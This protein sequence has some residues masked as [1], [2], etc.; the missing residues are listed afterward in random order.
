MR[1]HGV[2]L[3]GLREPDASIDCGNA[4]T[5]ARLL[6]GLLAGQGGRRFEL[7]GDDSLSSR[8]M[9]R[10]AA[11][12]SEMGAHVWRRVTGVC[13]CG[14]RDGPLSGIEHE[15]EVASAQV[16]SCVLLAGL[17]ADGRTTVVESVATRD[18]TERMLRAAGARLTTKGSRISVERAE[19]LELGEIDVP[20]DISAAA[21]FVVAA[22]LLPGSELI[23][24]G[25]GVNPSRTGLLDAL[26]R[27]GARIS[28]FNRRTQSGE[29]VA[30]LE[31]TH[32]ELVATEIVPAE[33]PRM[34]DELPLFALAAS[35]ARG[36]SRVRGAAELR[37]KESDRID[38][39]VDRPSRGRCA[40]AAD[41]G[42]LHGTRR[43]DAAARRRDR[44]CGRPPRRHRRRGRG[45]RLARGR[46]RAG[47]GGGGGIVPRLLRA[48]RVTR[49]PMIIAIDG[50][51]GAGKSTV[52][53]R[54]AERL[55]VRYLDTGAMYRAVTWLALRQAVPLEDGER[56][57]EL[58]SAH[59]VELD[60]AGHV[61]IAGED[62]TAAIRETRVDR[63]VPVVAAHPEVREVMRERQREL[64]AQADAVMEGR[65]IGTVVAPGADVKVYLTADEGVRTRRRQ[66]ERPDIGADALA[67]DLR[68]RDESDASRMEP[69][70]DAIHIDT[71][72]L[73]V[74]GVVS[75]IEELVRGV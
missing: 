59:P 6:P 65:D 22:T 49:Q 29:P 16:K 10:V 56:L 40:R 34:I 25:V 14:S 11:P 61:A 37:A 46:T 1:L 30:D 68:L 66:S 28:V 39:V 42:R 55:G 45:R 60:T 27:M 15:P 4:G 58:A 24:Q 51:A 53:R 32:A 21:P 57:G 20:G 74:D 38:S 8:P 64:A 12:L 70:E 18:H 13:R 73:D 3:S 43:A 62:V 26:E 19:R 67:T 54:L 72:T 7:T 36:T 17:L 33:V 52:A 71:S 23:L 47:R 69:A 35:M 44:R 50:P 31:V 9:D 2:G 5:L 41:S 75:L 48:S 63:A